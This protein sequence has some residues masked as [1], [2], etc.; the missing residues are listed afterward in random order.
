MLRAKLAEVWQFFGEVFG[1]SSTVQR[2]ERP[3]ADGAGET[4]PA[5][6]TSRASLD[7]GSH[8]TF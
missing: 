6:Q 3:T 5:V 7:R 2:R 8:G 1:G 4:K